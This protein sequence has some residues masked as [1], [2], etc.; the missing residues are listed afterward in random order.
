M[1]WTLPYLPFLI[2]LAH[3]N[4]QRIREDKVIHH[5]LNGLFHLTY[6]IWLLYFLE[7]RIALAF[8]PLVKVTFDTLLNHFRGLPLDYVPTKPK[9]LT[10]RIERYLFGNNGIIPK[11]LYL[12]ISVAILYL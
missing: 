6:A 9:A 12:F 2:F 1:I 7:L 11:I 5:W 10:D 8:F 4:A 3:N